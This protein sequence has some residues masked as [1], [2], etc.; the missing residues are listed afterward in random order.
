MKKSLKYMGLALLALG[1]IAC[2]KDNMA[3]PD[4]TIRGR[5]LIQG[6]G[7][8]QDGQPLQTSQG[9]DDMKIRMVEES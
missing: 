8:D 7:T 9:K 4:A 2:K 6:T 5:I 1:F 3:A